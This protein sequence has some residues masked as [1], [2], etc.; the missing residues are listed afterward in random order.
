M[1]HGQLDPLHFFQ[2]LVRV[3]KRLQAPQ[4]YRGSMQLVRMILAH[5]CFEVAPLL[6]FI[7]LSRTA[8]VHAA[9]LI[10][11]HGADILRSR[12]QEQP[13]Q[14]RQRFLFLAQFELI[15]PGLCHIEAMPG[16]YPH[17]CPIFRDFRT[18]A[19]RPI[20]LRHFF[21][22]AAQRLHLVHLHGEIAITAHQT[23]PKDLDHGS[24]H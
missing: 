22:E 2:P 3:E 17:V 10:H 15:G 14:L 9:A 21:Q 6:W 18:P 13:L 11:T 24:E 1:R 16:A 23:D 12:N 8:N 19:S 4:I 20:L 7:Y 5:P